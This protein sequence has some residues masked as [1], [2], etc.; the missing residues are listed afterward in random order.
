[1]RRSEV[2]RVAAEEFRGLPLAVHSFLHDVPLRDV[3]AVDLPGGGEGRAIGD[4]QSMI[5][6]EQL[7]GVNPVVSALFRLRL[8]LGSALGWDADATRVGG[9]SYVHRLPEE[10]RAR[11]VVVPGT[12]EGLFVTVYRLEREALAEVRNA[13]VHAFLCSVL[14]PHGNGYRLYWAVYVKPVSWLTPVYMAAIE[15]F[16]RFLVYPAILGRIR[17]AWIATY[18]SR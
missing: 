13:T 17:R 7:T 8:L 12:P 11:S 16:R 9:E 5:A 14:Q 4:V 1:M 18:S 10:L 3:S 2:T 15:P 6:P